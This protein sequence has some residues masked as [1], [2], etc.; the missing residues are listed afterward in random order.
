[1]AVVRDLKPEAVSLA[2][3]ELCPDDAAERDAGDF[4]AWLVAERVW[5]QYILYSADDVR[6]FDALR[7]KGL[8]A[9]DR[10]FCLFV[11]GRYAEGLVGDV[12]ELH[13]MLAAADCSE[14]PW[15]VCCFGPNENSAMLVAAS[16][17][18][19]VRIGFENNLQLADGTLAEDN[20][21]LID[22]FT[23][24]LTTRRPATADEIRQI[25]F[26][27]HEIYDGT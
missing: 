15:A 27:R 14:F 22:Q 13:E 19:H 6:R 17:G 4:F 16:Q 25:F 26:S 10:P 5:P 23:A 3:R 1:M 12:S 2:L 9:D 7:R 21:A 20:A 8:F 18:G 24:G 11:L